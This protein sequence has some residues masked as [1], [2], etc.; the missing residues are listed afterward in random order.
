MRQIN[1]TGLDLVKQHEGFRD[2][3]YVCPAGKLTI[4]YGHVIL[5]NEQNL[6]REIISKQKGEQLLKSDIAKAIKAVEKHITVPL[7]DNQFS[8][9]CSFTFN[10]GGEN[11]RKSTLRKMLNKR[12]YNAIPFQL[13]RWVFSGKKKLKGLVK[14]RKEESELFQ[15][16]V[17]ETCCCPCHRERGDQ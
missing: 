15:Q 6:K 16:A 10:L 13:S 5:K 12:K 14:R 9:L 17:I 11:L 1:K 8:A 2:K 7:N 4:G 3:A